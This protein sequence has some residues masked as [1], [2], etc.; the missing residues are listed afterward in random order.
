MDHMKSLEQLQGQTLE[1][2]LGRPFVIDRI[3]PERPDCLIRLQLSTGSRVCIS[4]NELQYAIEHA[5]NGGALDPMSLRTA[6]MR[7]CSYLGAIAAKLLDVPFPPPIDRSKSNRN[8]NWDVRVGSIRMSESNGMRHVILES[9][10][11]RWHV[12][13]RSWRED[14]DASTGVNYWIRREGAFGVDDESAIRLAIDDIECWL[15]GNERRRK[16]EDS[17]EPPRFLDTGV[18]IVSYARSMPATFS[19]RLQ[20]VIISRHERNETLQQIGDRYGVTRERIRQLE[21]KAIRAMTADWSRRRLR[22]PTSDG[23]GS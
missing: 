16:T 10:D 8:G 19:P 17:S 18:D 6:G 23:S 11:H 7:H 9:S 13:L 21:K 15:T 5:R 20:D 1:T 12:T 3:S 14:D 2:T 22:R 4:R